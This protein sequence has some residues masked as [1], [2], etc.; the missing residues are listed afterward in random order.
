MITF[1]IFSILQK[2]LF[3]FFLDCSLQ[4]N[5]IFNRKSKLYDCKARSIQEKI[6]D[7]LLEFRAVGIPQI[8]KERLCELTG[9]KSTATK[10]W[11]TAFKVV[12]DEGSIEIRKGKGGMLVE[13]KG[14]PR[15]P[16]REPG[17]V[18]ALLRKY[19]KE[20][21][22]QQTTHDVFDV[23]LGLGRDRYLEKG[24]L[25]NAVNKNVATKSFTTACKLLISFGVAEARKGSRGANTSYRLVQ[26]LHNDSFEAKAVE[27]SPMGC[28]HREAD[29]LLYSQETPIAFEYGVTAQDGENTLPSQ[30]HQRREQD[31][32][33]QNAKTASQPN[34]LTTL[35]TGIAFNEAS[36]QEIAENVITV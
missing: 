27:S 26:S 7:V 24:N 19:S 25:A 23:L 33:D 20:L 2:H 1:I 6:V 32:T 3:S 18:E 5:N 12:R 4:S 13:L 22:V 21:K 15:H 34:S 17:R 31:P 9:Y 36:N 14:H 35:S 8:P 11:A 30:Q 16:L 29:A 10:T 28:T